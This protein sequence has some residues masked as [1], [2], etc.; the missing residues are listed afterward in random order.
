MA[1]SP[2]DYPSVFRL[3]R[4]EGENKV[5]PL[6]QAIAEYIRPGMTVYVGREACAAMLE[7]CRRFWNTR[8]Q[9]TLACSS[10]S[11]Y[12]I[13][14]IYG[15]LV[16]KAITTVIVHSYPTPGRVSVA[17][18]A[19]R[20]G[21]LET[22]IWSVYVLQLRFMAAALGLPFMPTNSLLGSD[23]ALENQDNFRE[24]PDPFGSGHTGVVRALTPDVAIVH[25][26]A[27]DPCGN[28][29]LPFP[30]SEAWPARAARRTL[31]TVEKIVSSDVIRRYAHLV[32]IP[33]YQVSS[34]SLAPFS[35]HPDGL[36][37]RGVAGVNSYDGDYEYMAHFRQV[38]EDPA[39]LKEWV[40]QWLLNTPTYQGHLERLGKDRLARLVKKAGKGWQDELAAV[41]ISRST[42][43]S[44]GEMMTVAAARLL[45]Q[46]AQERGY[47]VLF[48]GAGSARV[49]YWLAY[50][51]L[52]EQG[53]SVD[54]A[55][56][57]GQ[58]GFSPRPGRPITGDLS[59]IRSS[60]MLTD[61][62]EAW[63]LIIGG[64]HNSCLSCLGA[65]QLDK[66]GNI[67][68]TQL[69]K[70][71]LFGGGGANDA[72]TSQELLI[73]VAEHSPRRLVDRVSY[74]TVPGDKVF[75]AV[76]PL[77]VMEK[78]DGELMLTAVLPGPGSREEKV[79]HLKGS[80]GW[81]LKVAEQLH[82]VLPPTPRELLVLRYLDP[83]GFYTR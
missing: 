10:I 76:T 49:A 3:R 48:G 25:G 34:V 60:K 53:Y 39:Q 56:G 32:K 45:G 59:Y 71:R 21:R 47:K 24:L 2:P 35:F 55:T 77:G 72:A 41:D 6:S 37:A 54:L 73:I 66:F 17:E 31:V 27:A 8:P 12:A 78:R 44:P 69:G 28:T 29:I 38:C 79:A 30:C 46:R 15:D 67:N 81:E 64:G 43:F 82:E 14:P 33:A 4:Q 52:R 50:Y 63:G 9:F 18:Q 57:G 80:T 58:L 22:E 40:E 68:S 74:V 19:Q 13:L 65:A 23:L 1:S 26:I 7:L 16:K 83:R 61:A 42:D 70:V 51:L 75:L 11:G 62:L 36:N 20:E 5:R